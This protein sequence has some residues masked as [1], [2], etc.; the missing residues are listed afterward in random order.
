VSAMG[1]RGMGACGVQVATGVQ[2]AN[3][4]IAVADDGN[5][6]SRAVTSS[7]DASHSTLGGHAMKRWGM[8]T[9]L[10]TR[11][12]AVCRFLMVMENTQPCPREPV[13]QETGPMARTRELTLLDVIQAV[14]E[15]AENDVASMDAAA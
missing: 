14:S 3:R 9:S 8:V 12:H 13:A 7:D 1:N 15:V 4:L 2:D 5:D 10:C 6:L 11:W